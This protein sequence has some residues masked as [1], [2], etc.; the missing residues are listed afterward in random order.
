[1]LVGSRDGFIWLFINTGST[2]APV[3]TSKGKIQANGVD[4]DAGF[5]AHPVVVDWN[6][7]GKK[8]LVIATQDDGVRVYL[9]TVSNA[10]PA[11]SGFTVA[12]TNIAILNRCSAEVY[13]LNGDGKKDIIAGEKEGGV[14]FYENTG[15]DASPEI[16]AQGKKMKLTSGQEITMHGS[17]HIDMVDWDGNGSMD[18]IVGVS[19]ADIHIFLN[20]QSV[21]INNEKKH[22]QYETGLADILIRQNGNKREINLF[23]PTAGVYKITAY[24]LN[25]RESPFM[26]NDFFTRGTHKISLNSL[27][28]LQNVSLFE[29]QSGNRK[30]VKK[31]IIIE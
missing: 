4:L 20:A 21:N 31:G 11:F 6:N 25:G 2:T 26:I 15:T 1:M 8:D 16:S 29:V 23:I 27:L 18:L 17:A 10:A 7:D 28:F 12:V 14:Y 22:L 19:Q 9:N 5:S 24:S 3:L 30:I 13:D